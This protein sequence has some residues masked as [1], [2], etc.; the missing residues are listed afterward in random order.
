MFKFFKAEKSGLSTEIT[1]ANKNQEQLI[2]NYGLPVVDNPQITRLLAAI[3]F[4]HLSPEKVNQLMDKV[5]RFYHSGE[6]NSLMSVLAERAQDQ[7][8]GREIAGRVLMGYGGTNR[9][10]VEASGIIKL[11]TGYNI[12]PGPGLLE[13]AQKLGMEVLNN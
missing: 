4:S 13:K 2:E 11:M 8:A 6:I 3:D 1:S 7:Q 9:Y 5:D 10:F 12:N